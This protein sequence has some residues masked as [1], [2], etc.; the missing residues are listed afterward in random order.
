MSTPTS[1]RIAAILLW[2]NAFGFGLPCLLAI[3]SLL[4][5]RSVPT[6][7][8]FPAYGGGPLERLGVHTN[9]PLVQRSF[10][11][12]R[13]RSC[14]ISA[15]GRTPRRRLPRTRAPTGG[16]GV[17]VGIRP[18][19]PTTVR[20]R[21]N[22]P[23]PAQLAQPEIATTVWQRACIPESRAR[24]PRHHCPGRA[25][26]HPMSTGSPTARC[27]SPERSDALRSAKSRIAVYVPE[28]M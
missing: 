20:G 3:G 14:R 26:G 28:A 1:V 22:S 4:A 6:I 7:M 21:S 8:G 15:V 19:T 13:W 10:S 11:S 23:N 25:T 24:A 12:A 18:A 27:T 5:G 9:I 16:R 17:L 2:V